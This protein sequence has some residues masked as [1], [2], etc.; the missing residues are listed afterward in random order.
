MK[1]WY[2]YLYKGVDPKTKEP[3]LCRRYYKKKIKDN[4]LTFVGEAELNDE[5]FIIGCETHY[6]NIVDLNDIRL[7]YSAT[8]KG[9][10]ITKFSH[11]FQDMLIKA[12]EGIIPYISFAECRVNNKPKLIIKG[13]HF[14]IHD[15]KTMVYEE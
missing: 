3:Y 11:S 13:K 8:L 15:D 10:V 1:K 14:N 2:I 4:N 7:E 6:T 12:K 9:G 5:Y